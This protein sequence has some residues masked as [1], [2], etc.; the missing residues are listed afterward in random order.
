MTSPW[1]V[2]HL[3]MFVLEE[4]G[5]V[6]KT[7]HEKSLVPNYYTIIILVDLCIS[8]VSITGKLSAMNTDKL[9]I[10]HGYLCILLFICTRSLA[11]WL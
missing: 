4:F 1:L 2:S 11:N 10:K 3:V 9:Q 8:A 6:V 7:Y 5:I